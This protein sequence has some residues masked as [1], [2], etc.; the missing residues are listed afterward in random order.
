MHDL[1]FP[2]PFPCREV[3]EVGSLSGGSTGPE[4]WQIS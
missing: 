4:D 1:V 3:Q 2:F